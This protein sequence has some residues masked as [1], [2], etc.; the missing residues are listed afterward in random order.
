MPISLPERWI[1]PALAYHRLMKKVRRV[2]RA[3]G[4]IALVERNADL[5]GKHQGERCFVLGSGNS[6]KDFD[7]SRLQHEVVFGLNNFFVHPDFDRVFSGTARKYYLFAPLH[8]PQTR[9]EW[10][11]WLGAMS[12]AL[13]GREV[14]LLAGLNSYRVSAKKLIEE[15]G[16][17][18]G[19]PIYYYLGVIP[20]THPGYRF[21]REDLRIDR[22][23]QGAMASSVYAVMFARAMG[24]G[25][26]TLVGMDH[27]YF[28]YESESDMRFYDSAVHQ[29]NEMERIFQGRFY[30]EELLRQYR[31]FRH[32][33]NIQQVSDMTIQR[34]SSRGL[35]RIFPVATDAEMFGERSIR[36]GHVC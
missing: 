15:H 33:R 20:A 32:Y 26:V 5:I 10:I 4:Y 12:D 8:P 21:D 25:T 34:A 17:F 22:V 3:S 16:F 18:K 31:I 14:T 9:A 29:E 13:S 7:L 24:F 19:I 36:N 27:D 2:L 35:L 23:M 1:P 28:L 11:D 6:V 30:E